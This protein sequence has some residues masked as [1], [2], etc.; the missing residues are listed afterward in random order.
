[1]TTP[2][3]QPDEMPADAPEADYLEQ[4][5]PATPD[6]PE[7]VAGPLV[8]DPDVEANPADVLE[9]AVPVPVDDEEERS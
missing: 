2:T 8:V 7:D 3:D 9:Q 5:Q 1:M 4:H 6:D